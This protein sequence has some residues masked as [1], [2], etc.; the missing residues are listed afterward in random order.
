MRVVQRSGRRVR[1]A[2][3]CRRVGDPRL[4]HT[5]D[6]GNVLRCEPEEAAGQAAAS[7]R[8]LAQDYGITDRDDQHQRRER[9]WPSSEGI[10][11][12]DRPWAKRAVEPAEVQ[13]QPDSRIGVA[14]R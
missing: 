4:A 13:Q 14:A 1:T 11:R 6:A 10:L 8:R 7:A 12:L 3:L 9:G 2:L 5:A